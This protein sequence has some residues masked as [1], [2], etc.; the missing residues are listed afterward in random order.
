MDGVPATPASAD[1]ALAFFKAY[2]VSHI[3]GTVRNHPDQ[4]GSAEVEDTRRAATDLGWL[5]EPNVAVLT[6]RTK[7]VPGVSLREELCDPWSAIPTRY[8]PPKEHRKVPPRHAS[9]GVTARVVSA[10]SST[11]VP[12]PLSAVGVLLNAV[13][14]T[15]EAFW[16][17]PGSQVMVPL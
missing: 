9:R 8:R 2:F 12:W 10:G 4:A 3:Y 5:S 11:Q 1:K 14:N 16:L 6:A 7:I 17:S 13:V 15:A